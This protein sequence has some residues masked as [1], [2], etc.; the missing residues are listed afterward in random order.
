MFRQTVL[1]VSGLSIIILAVLIEF[2]LLYWFISPS[3]LMYYIFA[4]SLG[5]AIILIMRYAFQIPFPHDYARPR[6]PDVGG[7]L[8]LISKLKEGDRLD[9]VVGELNPDV[10]TQEVNKQLINK[11]NEL[12]DFKLRL[13]IGPEVHQKSKSFLENLIKFVPDKVEIYRKEMRPI[14]HFRLLEN[15]ELILEPPHQPFTKSKYWKFSN[16][17]YLNKKYH[18]IFEDYSQE[19]N[20]CSKIND[21]KFVNPTNN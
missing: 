21:I 16:S 3:I 2:S 1:L 18:K 9:I 17:Y 4:L 14:R 6:N 12:K 13:V 5:I 15:K 8:N 7:Y 19:A 20:F 10:V 11:M